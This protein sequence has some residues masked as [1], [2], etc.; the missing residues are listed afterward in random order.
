MTVVFAGGGTGGHLYPALAIADALRERD[1]K[2]AFVGTADRLETAIVPKA[3]YALH[4]IASYPLNRKL[5][6][7]LARTIVLNL[8]GTLQ[9]LRL[10]AA[11]R[12]DIVIAT[13][14]YVCF[15][16][17]LAARLRRLARRS[18]AAIALFEPNAAPGL[19]S[20]LVAPHVDEVWGAAAGADRAFRGRYVQTGTPVR[21]A[22][23]RLPAR[24]SAIARFGLD[25]GRK[26]LVA[27]GGSQG[28]RT[29][30]DAL[31]GVVE[32]GSLPPDWQL[33]HITG[34][35]DYDRVQTALANSVQSIDP[36]RVVVRPYLDDMS[37][38]YACADLLLTR[39]GASTLAELA[40][41]GKPAILVPYPF[42]AEEHQA[43]N[44]AHFEASGAAVVVAD[45][46]LGPVSL[47]GLLNQVTSRARLEALS[48]GARRLAG[49]DPIATI[50][51]RVDML[52]PRKNG[53]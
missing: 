27:M 17:V 38:G 2:I 36:N 22:L 5:S 4:T 31:L 51:A 12:P 24:E 13:G 10:L 3:G 26:T 37:T 45:R 9:S 16:V 47:R 29:I 52:A 28:A 39:A 30:N 50:L 7:D 23:Q 41:L 18:A 8:K 53:Q 15:P 49:G 44:A 6:F 35:S 1:A 42:A 32:S 40:A 33:L 34:P 21:L 11:L 14:G 20:R 48:E 25:S 46:D 43:A 19:T